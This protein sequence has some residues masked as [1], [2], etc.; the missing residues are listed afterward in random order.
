VLLRILVG[1]SLA[2]VVAAAQETPALSK[3]GS[4]SG[5]VVDATTGAPI[6]AVMVQASGETNR[7]AV[8]QTDGQG[9]YKLPNLAA[10]KY[11]MQAGRNNPQIKRVTVNPGQDVG[12]IEF[13][14]AAS[15][16]ITG[17]IL[18]EDKEPV[19]RV[20]VRPLWRIYS[21]GELRE[22]SGGTSIS[23]DKGEFRLS[24]LLPGR[25]YVVRAERAAWTAD[26]GA[27]ASIDPKLR[28]PVTAPTYYGDTTSIESALPLTLRPGETRDGVDLRMAQSPSYC[29]EGVLDA[30]GA[31]RYSL[32]SRGSGSSIPGNA[33]ADGKFRICG[34]WPGQ[35]ELRV[36]QSA[37]G[38][39][40]LFGAAGITVVKED[41][42]NIRVFGQPGIPLSGEIVWAGTPPDKPIDAQ[43]NVSLEPL[44]RSTVSGEK[45]GAQATIPGEFS[46]PSL[47]L[48]EYT[49]AVSG[50]PQGLYI[51]DITYGGNSALYDPLRFGGA[52]GGAG[53][54]I[55]VARD[56]GS[57]AVRT[58]DKDGKPVPDAFVYIMPA[59]ARSEPA[60]A[61]RLVFGQ[62]D[63][64]GVFT[65]GTLAPG[66][67]LVLAAALVYD[68]GVETVGKLWRARNKAKEVEVGAGITAQVTLEPV[69]LE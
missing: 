35:Y 60:L 25:A 31:S 7:G 39:V 49:V 26:G 4:I 45:L 43:A 65:T 57:I 28:K 62:P 5:V 17:R 47:L 42:R 24:D 40:P 9:R 21:R 44:N 11:L 32:W 56:G 55:L 58:N 46:F 12:P 30:G 64:N 29:I 61:S 48:A 16:T 18:D 23:N 10:G 41:V 34:V 22:V 19:P 69:T 52:A 27:P 67:Y 59:D 66:K 36:L 20:V 50:L 68:S 33:G 51:K 13:R 3:P 6:P 63:Q 1:L 2:A 53:L 38:A 8:T 37:A 54:R 14:V 15:G